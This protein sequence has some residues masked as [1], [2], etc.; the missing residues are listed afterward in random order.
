MS[1]TPT[2][3]PPI[4]TF[5]DLHTF[6]NQEESIGKVIWDFDGALVNSEPVQKEAYRLVLQEEGIVPHHLFFNKY[7]G[8]QEKDI[9]AGICNEYSLSIP[10]ETLRK[11]RLEKL[12]E[13]FMPKVPP[14]WFARPIIEF[15]IE[16]GISSVI[17]SSGNE[18]VIREY[19][20]QWSLV[21][22]FESISATNSV[23]PTTTK[24]ERIQ[25]ATTS[26][27]QGKALV[28]ED[29][30]AYLNVATKSGASTL[31]VIHPLN[32]L[33]PDMCNA[34]IQ[35]CVQETLEL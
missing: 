34:L 31:G 13:I 7:V 24:T 14:N 17:V 15:F 10:V 21:D 33:A 35:C 6:L 1:H 5:Q 2:P 29:S 30:P 26:T 4:A 23:T 16:K 32:N 11:R 9:W 27:T 22:L 8:T 25:V 20:S 12:N 18:S 3:T 19:L 28:I